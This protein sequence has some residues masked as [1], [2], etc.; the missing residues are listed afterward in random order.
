[1]DRSNFYYDQ[2]VTEG[3]MNQAFDDVERMEQDRTI[4]MDLWGVWTGLD[5]TEQA[6]PDL[7]VKVTAGVAQ[8]ELGRRIAMDSDQNV[9]LTSYVPVGAGDD[10]IIH[11]YVKNDD[12]ESD[13]RVDGHLVPLKYRY[14]ES[15]EFAIVSGT[16][17]SPPATPPG[18]VANQVLIA[19]ITLSQGMSAITNSEIEKDW[20]QTQRQE[21]GVLIRRGRKLA[22]NI[23]FDSTGD[24]DINYVHAIV[25]KTGSPATNG[26]SMGDNAIVD[27]GKIT[28]TAP[29][30]GLGIDMAG[31]EIDNVDDITFDAGASGN[32]S[33]VDQI[34]FRAGSGT[35]LAMGARDMANVAS[36]TFTVGVGGMGLDLNGRDV[37]GVRVLN[38]VATGGGALGI[39]LND[40][41]IDD[42]AAINLST[43]SGTGIDLNG[44]DIIDA[45]GITASGTVK[46]DTLSADSLFRYSSAKSRQKGMPLE[47]AQPTNGGFTYVNGGA[48]GQGYWL[49]D[50]IVTDPLQI[51]IVVPNGVEI[52]SV[53]ALV[54][55]V[56][57][58]ANDIDLDIY[59]LTG[60]WS[61]PAV[62]MSPSLLATGSNAGTSGAEVITATLGSP[63]T[64]N[65]QI[66]RYLISLDMN[67]GG[68]HKIHG[69]RVVFNITNLAFN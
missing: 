38:F 63:E 62:P 55:V 67:G 15:Y 39:D 51:P 31:T 3:E 7:T 45:V 32:I 52:T 58:S 17:S 28:M 12:V 34:T 46:G 66:N 25:L 4:D 18:I 64:V 9:D 35:G 54:D 21:G 56:S 6:V 65:N 41:R 60:D 23:E 61:T 11:L 14:T 8:D 68:A 5:V 20:L 27:C 42:C 37:Q 53:Q 36:I 16:P 2:E 69:V 33:A 59:K 49:W 30:P 43:G 26:I 40:R 19:E 24:F 10:V 13:D 48:A 57:G 22:E 50:T 47:W 44:K 1:M 29:G